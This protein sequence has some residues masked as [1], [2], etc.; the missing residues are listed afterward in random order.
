MY[1]IPEA[2]RVYHRYVGRKGIL[3]DVS[4]GQTDLEG[5]I[6]RILT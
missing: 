5:M 3:R 1:A 4:F 6:Q 2:I